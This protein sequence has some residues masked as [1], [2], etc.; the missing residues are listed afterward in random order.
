MMRFSS[1][2]RNH[3]C[4]ITVR[5]ILKAK[6]M[7]L[8]QEF[9]SRG[10]YHP[11][12]KPHLASKKTVRHRGYTTCS[13]M[14]RPLVTRTWKFQASICW[15][16]LK[17]LPARWDESSR[18]T[19]ATQSMLTAMVSTRLFTNGVR[20]KSHCGASSNRL[21]IKTSRNLRAAATSQTRTPQT[22]NK[23]LNRAKNNTSGR[24]VP[25]QTRKILKTSKIWSL[26]SRV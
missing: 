12:Y 6:N 5:Y 19:E 20:T 23:V 26:V 24:K 10:W 3:A 17:S 4:R 18:M 8:I 22:T 2:R 16:H 21:N 15:F 13:A 1:T 7:R 14:A 9:T 11:L 25:M